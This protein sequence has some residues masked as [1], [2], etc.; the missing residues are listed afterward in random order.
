MQN[1]G[2]R[3][4]TF[5]ATACCAFATRSDRNDEA[6]DVPPCIFAGHRQHALSLDAGRNVGAAQNRIHRLLDEFRLALLDDQNRFFPRAEAD[7]FGVD[8]RIGDVEHVERDAAIAEHIGEPEDFERAQRSIVHAA[9]H[10]DADVVGLAIEHLVELVLLDE[11]HGGRPAL[12]DLFPLVQVARGRQHD[13]VGVAHGA[14]E[15]VFEREGPAR[16]VARGEAAI[17]VTGADAQLQHHRG[18]G[19]LRQ[20]EAGLDR[21]YD[22]RQVRTRVEQPDLRLH[23]EG[24]AALLHD[25]GALAVVLADDDQCAA[26]DAARGEVGERVG[27]DV[28]AHRRLEGRGAAQRVIDRRRERGG[29]GGFVRARLEADAEIAQH[30]VGIGE[31]ID[32]VRDRRALIAGDVGH[33]GLEQRLGDGENALAAEF[34][35]GAEPELRDLAFERAFCHPRPFASSAARPCTP[36]RN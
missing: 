4:C 27:G 5:P 10:D 21:P 31:H 17:D 33:A 3:P 23:R 30:I 28:G 19:R 34:L 25:R 13:A 16:I 2:G 18:V 29:G 8:Q 20:L 32:Q 11:A 22:R 7:E 26:G 14:F 24:V 6:I 36:A 1:D 35:P 12:F 9:L 15:R